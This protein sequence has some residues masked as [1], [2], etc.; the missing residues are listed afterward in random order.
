MKRLSTPA[1]STLLRLAAVALACAPFAGCSRPAAAPQRPADAL[2]QVGEEFVTVAQFDAALARRRLVHADEPA[3]RAVLEDL[4]RFR[5]DVQEARRRGF[6][7]DPELQAAFERLLVARVREESRERAAAAATVTPAEVEAALAAEAGKERGPDRLRLAQIVVEAPA[8]AS[9]ELRAERR[10]KLEAARARATELDP[11]VGYAALAAELSFDQASKFRGGDLGYLTDRTLPGEWS[12]EVAQAALALRTPGEQSPILETPRG[13]LL[14]R[15]TERAEGAQ[16]P[17][18][19][20]QAKVR[21][22]LERAKLQAFE[23][24][25]TESA[26][27]GA[28][29]V[30]DEAR[31]K[32]LPAAP[33]APALTQVP[34]SAPGR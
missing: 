27:A 25:Q 15:L 34:P 9:P 5:A 17:A 11:R 23:R 14:L 33:P 29:V 4:L 6:E 12:P 3:R 30:I 21:A 26:L 16:P 28:R 7:R 32:A 19:Q 8:Q 13:F 10:A 2:A 22:R 20:L 31:W 1:Y 18:E 24:T